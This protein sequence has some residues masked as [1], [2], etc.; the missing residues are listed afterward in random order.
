MLTPFQMGR[1]QALAG[2]QD[3]PEWG[4]DNVSVEFYDEWIEGWWSLEREEFE[5]IFPE[6]D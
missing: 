1:Y 6:G 3:W 4:R 2:L 5:R